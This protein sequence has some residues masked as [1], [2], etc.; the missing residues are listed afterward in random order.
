MKKLI[1]TLTLAIAYLGAQAQFE[2]MFSQYMF[3]QLFLNPAYAGSQKYITGT[4]LYRTQWTTWNKTVDFG[5][6]APQTGTIGIDGPIGNNMGWGVNMINDRIGVNNYFSIAGNYSYKVMLTEKARLSFGI[7][8]GGTRL[9]NDAPAI[10]NDPN[11]PTMQRTRTFAIRTGFGMFFNTEKFYISL[12]TPDLLAY[13]PRMAFNLDITQGSPFRRH[14][15]LGSGYMFTLNNFIKLRPSFLMK[16][17]SRTVSPAQFDFNLHALFNDRF[18]IGASYRTQDAVVGMMEF[19]INR[20][21]RIGYAYDH[22]VSS[23]AYSFLGPTHEF[24]LGVDLGQAV[25]RMRHPRYF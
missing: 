2:P 23:V 13:Y 22:K 4:M 24:M 20:N 17:Q 19:L 18:W 3:N 12:A 6:I 8:V 15:F 1:L 9:A 25:N 5:G 14:Y 10:V 16:Y 21:F 7:R 11:D